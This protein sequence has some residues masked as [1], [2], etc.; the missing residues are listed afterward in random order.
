MLLNDHK[1]LFL[2]IIFGVF[3]LFSILYLG[4]RFTAGYFPHLNALHINFSPDGR[5]IA[6]SPTVYFWNIENGKVINSVYPE[7]RYQNLRDRLCFSPDGRFFSISRYSE[8]RVRLYK[9]QTNK[10]LISFKGKYAIFSPDGKN[11]VIGQEHHKENIELLI[12]NIK[13]QKAKGIIK[14]GKR[15]IESPLYLE[16]LRN[17]KDKSLILTAHNVDG[18]RG[19]KSGLIQIWD[20]HKFKCKET[21]ITSITSGELKNIHAADNNIIIY[22]A[23]GIKKIDLQIKNHKLTAIHGIK[24]GHLNTVSSDG[25]L[26]A[27]DIGGKIVVW[28]VQNKK[29]LM[30]KEIGSFY[31]L[32]MA[33]SPDGKQL[34]AG[35]VY[36]WPNNGEIWLY[37]IE[38]GKRIK[39]L[40]PP[41]DLWKTLRAIIKHP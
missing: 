13:E 40:R 24:M 33:F 32:S 28:D 16:P 30:N 5:T 23:S 8:N 9:M 38:S 2:K 39:V 7:F 18:S 15:D 22:M 19:Y 37:N 35:S 26:I 14:L 25:K 17:G 27:T 4:P 31:L 6:S 29:K 41:L 20:I 1:R 11:L 3:L 21:I 36:N 34:A 10:E 12:W